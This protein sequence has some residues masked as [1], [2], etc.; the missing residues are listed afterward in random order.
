[1]G[2]PS[3][4]AQWQPTIPIDQSIY[5]ASTTQLAPLG[6]RLEVGDRV[7]YYTWCSA[8]AGRGIIIGA[9]AP[10][11]SHNGALCI[12][13]ATSAGVSTP[14]IT[15]GVAIT[16]NYYAEGYVGISKGTMGGA[17]YRIKSHPAIGSAGTG[18]LS[19]YDALYDD[20]AAADECGLTKN[21]Y[22]A[23]IVGS[24]AK[25]TVGMPMVDVAAGSYAWLQTYGPAAP[26]NSGATAAAW[27]VRVDNTGG[28]ELFIG[29]A[30]IGC[31]FVGINYNLAGT[32]AEF[33]PIFL[34]I[35]P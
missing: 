8:S 29:T 26:V 24:T 33:T 22:S 28:V 4:K 18:T 21:I 17:T 14:T 9:A 7:F 11:A 16:A 34:T 35:R 31:E 27:P 1:M 13:A 3:N 15:A 30:T 19:L 5:E 2:V 32:A 25:P 12:F 23:P 10:V 20:V 6:T